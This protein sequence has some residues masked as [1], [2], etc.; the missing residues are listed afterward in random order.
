MGEIK[1][2]DIVIVNFSL[3]E[4]REQKGVR[5]ALVISGNPFNVS[6]VVIVC[7]ITSQIKKFAGNLLLT[8]NS[9][10]GLKKLSEVLIGQIRAISIKRINKRIG[11]VGDKELAAVFEGLDLLLDR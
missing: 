7:P 9:A 10:N 1:Q 8:P 4:G 6:D 5:P 2:K 3:T 11:S